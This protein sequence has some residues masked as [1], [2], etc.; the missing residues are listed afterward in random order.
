MRRPPPKPGTHRPDM[1]P[2]A[3]SLAM[4]CAILPCGPTAAIILPPQAEPGR[5]RCHNQEAAY[6]FLP[7]G[8]I[9]FLLVS[10]QDHR[11]L[12]DHKRRICLAPPKSGSWLPTTGPSNNRRA[13]L[14][15]S[16]HARA[17]TKPHRGSVLRQRAAFVHRPAPTDL[18]CV[19]FNHTLHRR[20][21]LG[22]LQYFNKLSEQHVHL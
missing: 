15:T 10:A 17:L 14:R 20:Q 1:Y 21:G 11:R 18:D 16:A 22:L 12:N 6:R 19:D 3:R 4:T 7:S 9:D 5:E 8:L 2:V 13:A